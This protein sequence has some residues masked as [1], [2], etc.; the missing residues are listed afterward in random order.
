MATLQEN[1]WRWTFM[2]FW[3]ISLP[4]GKRPH[5]LAHSNL[6]LL[7]QRYCTSAS[8]GWGGIGFYRSLFP[9]LWR[10]IF[11]NTAVPLRTAHAWWR[12]PEGGRMTCPVFRVLRPNTVDLSTW[13][14]GFGAGWLRTPWSLTNYSVPARSGYDL[15]HS[16]QNSISNRAGSATDLRVR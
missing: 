12:W 2:S 4:R 3:A 15:G 1:K 13:P 7:L 11:E 5:R 6:K 10:H 9:L 8:L 16:F 14:R